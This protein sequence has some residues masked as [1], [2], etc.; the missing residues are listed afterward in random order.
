MSNKACNGRRLALF[1][2]VS[3][4]VCTSIIKYLPINFNLDSDSF[5][6]FY[7]AI[8]E[9]ENILLAYDFGDSDV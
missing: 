3:V 7:V 9:E 4:C 5:T 6:A 2:Y 1:C 8:I